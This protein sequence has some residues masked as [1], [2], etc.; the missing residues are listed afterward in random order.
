MLPVWLFMVLIVL[1]CCLLYISMATDD[2]LFIISKNKFKKIQ[3][4]MEDSP[5]N[6]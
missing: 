6:E 1:I 2:N 3:Y 4:R 5:E